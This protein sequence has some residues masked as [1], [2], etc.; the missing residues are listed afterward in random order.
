M[1]KCELC[2][3]PIIW[4]QDKKN[5]DRFVPFDWTNEE[6]RKKAWRLVDGQAVKENVWTDHF[7]T[8]PGI[9][10]KKGVKK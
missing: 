10:R 6:F 7:E 2:A 8:C 9:K 3:A 5:P 4:V 1:P